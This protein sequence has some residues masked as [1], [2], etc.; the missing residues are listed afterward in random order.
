MKLKYGDQ[1][2]FTEI[3][4][5]ILYMWVNRKIEDSDK[6]QNDYTYWHMNKVTRDE[7]ISGLGLG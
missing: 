5:I 1:Y 2:I 4:K 7:L 3:G 6:D